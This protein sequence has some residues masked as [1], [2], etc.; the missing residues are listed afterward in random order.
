MLKCRKKRS[1]ETKQAAEP[2]SYMSQILKLGR[3]F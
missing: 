3:E 2:D 1:E